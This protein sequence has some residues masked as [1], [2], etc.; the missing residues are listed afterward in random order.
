MVAVLHAALIGGGLNPVEAGE[1]KRILHA[2]GTTELAAVPRKVAVLDLGALDILDSIGVE[3]AGVPSMKPEAWPDYLGKY[4]GEKYAKIGSLFEPDLEALRQ[5]KPDLIIVG[6]RSAGKYPDVSAIAPTLDLS[7]TTVGFIP[8]VVQNTLTL[9]SVFSR[10]KEASEKVLELL[11]EIRQLQVKASQQGRGLLL[12]GVGDRVMAQQPLTRFGIVYELIGIEPVVTAEDAPPPGERRPRNAARGA[13]ESG[14]PDP[15]AEAREKE[16]AA[17]EA[18]RFAKILG[19]EP[20]WLFVIDRNSAFKERANASDVLAANPGVAKSGAWQKK[21]VV[22]LDGAGWYLVGGGLQQLRNSIRQIDAAFDK[23][24][25][26]V[27]PA[28]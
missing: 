17:V 15:A 19:R 16:R 5:L 14:V 6:G 3:A 18:A 23:H 4:A 7:T 10:E 12:F 2:Q 27:K 20:D 11:G 22:H 24:P 8:S 9:G 25:P 28:S 21:K 26:A 1:S 13:G